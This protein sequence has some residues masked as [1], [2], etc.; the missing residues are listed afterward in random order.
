MQFLII[1]FVLFICASPVPAGTVLSMENAE[2]LLLENNLEIRSKKIGVQKSDAVVLEAKAL[3]NPVAQY[4]LESMKNGLRET[5]ET[6]SVSQSLDIAGKRGS[7]VQ[8]AYKS[9]EARAYFLEHEIAGLLMQMK[10]SYCKI[11]LLTENVKALSVISGVFSDVVKKTGDRVSAGDVSEADLMKLSGEKNI[12]I[13]GL[14]TLRSDLK[15][16]KKRLGLMLALE[17]TDFDVS[18]ELAVNPL[19]LSIQ[20]LTSMAVQKR[21]DIQGQHRTVEA[22]ELLLTAAKRDAIP[23]IDL[24]AGY[25]KRTGGFNGFVFGVSI[26]LPFLNRNQGGIARAEADLA[27]EKVVYEALKKNTTTEISI[28]FERIAALETRIAG[29]SDYI[30]TARE[31]TGIAGIAYE[32]G[33][34]GLLELLDAARSEKELVMEN[35]S[36]IYEYWSA[37]FELER[38]I[39]AGLKATGGTK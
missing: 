10:Q 14:E 36:A 6:Y 30:K 20:E 33:E 2:R 39:G 5:E 31:L 18:G 13:R 1:M 19:S 26:P 11:L 22:A 16:E 28:L 9:S 4:S 38:A 37:R 32:E 7:K 25:K 12:I 17:D 15:A 29:L 21:P 3:P 24:E 23:P 34:A 8:A 35:N 27:E